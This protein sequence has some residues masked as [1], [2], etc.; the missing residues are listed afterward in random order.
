VESIAVH[1][2]VNR[3]LLEVWQQLAACFLHL[4]Q[5]HEEQLREKEFGTVGQP[6]HVSEGGEE[7]DKDIGTED[8]D[9]YLVWKRRVWDDRSSWWRHKHFHEKSV[10]S[11]QQADGE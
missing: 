8:D 10:N 3:G 1:L 4:N 2:D 9:P 11:E 7:I 5:R 6:Q